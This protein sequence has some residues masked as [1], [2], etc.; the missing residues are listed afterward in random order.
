MRKAA[1]FI[2][3]LVCLFGAFAAQASADRQD[4]ALLY[5][6]R[7]NGLWGYIDRSGQWVIEPAWAWAEPFWGDYAIVGQWEDGQKGSLL[8][9]ARGLPL[10]EGTDYDPATYTH[11]PLRYG[12]ISRT[13]EQVL[14]IVYISVY[15]EPDA[16]FIV[17][18]G[19]ARDDSPYTASI[20]N[21]ENRQLIGPSWYSNSIF[22]EDNGSGLYLTQAWGGWGYMNALGDMVIPCQYDAA[23]IFIEGS[24]C[25]TPLNQENPSPAIIDVQGNAILTNV[26]DAVL[27]SPFIEG[28][29]LIRGE[30]GWGFIDRS[31]QIVIAPEWHDANV[32]VNGLAWVSALDEH[33]REE[34]FGFINRHGILV[35]PAIYDSIVPFDQNGLALARR[36][37]CW[38]LLDKNGH[39]TPISCDDTDNA[40]VDWPFSEGLLPIVSG[41]KCGFVDTSGTLALPAIWDEV[42]SFDCGLAYVY[43]DGK[44]GYISPSGDTVW[45]EP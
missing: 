38:L 11:Q 13:G 23:S 18:E 33:T 43:R 37:S 25:V 35:I 39:E 42:H 45:M 19:S 21:K 44:M 34:R 40:I 27:F 31:S 15:T 32:F 22:V 30:H 14:P 1:V 9:D 29:A 41:G 3:L 20:F 6:A 4:V 10:I 5:P 17:V 8:P 16:C 24:A 12:V 36:E 2:M 26:E 28:L 7:R